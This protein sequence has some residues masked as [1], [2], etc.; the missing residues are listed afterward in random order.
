MLFLISADVL[1]LKRKVAKNF[2]LKSDGLEKDFNLF[3]TIWESVKEHFLT[4]YKKFEQIVNECYVGASLTPNLKNVQ[5]M[6]VRIDKEYSRRSR[7][8]DTISPRRSFVVD[9]IHKSV[10]ITVTKKTLL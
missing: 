10:D 3:A 4:R 7:F 1:D 5:Q 6:F 2:D 8:F 9:A